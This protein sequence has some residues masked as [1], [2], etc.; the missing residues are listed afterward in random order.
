M[1]NIIQCIELKMF[2]PDEDI[3][4]QGDT[5]KAFYIIAKGE[6]RCRVRDEYGRW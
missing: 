2:Q 6:C 1:A 3:I 5:A 4:R